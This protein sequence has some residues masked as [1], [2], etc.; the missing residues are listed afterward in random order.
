[1]KERREHFKGVIW[2]RGDGT[3][4]VYDPRTKLYRYVIVGMLVTDA[5]LDN[6]DKDEFVIDGPVEMGH[7]LERASHRAP[8]HLTGDATSVLCGLDT[9]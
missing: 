6:C 4:R 8:K 2:P 3:L 5:P 7:I 1:M 9:L